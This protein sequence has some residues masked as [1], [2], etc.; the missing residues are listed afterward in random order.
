MLICINLIGILYEES[1]NQFKKIHS[2]LPTP[3]KISKET[4][5][6]QFIHVSALGIENA[7]DSAYAISKLEGEKGVRENFEN[8]VILKPS[9]VYSIDDNF[10]TNF[11]T[12]LS[13]FPL[14]PL[15]IM[16]KQSL[17]LYMFQI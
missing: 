11:M 7:K 13:R 3:I 14:M 15:F 1:K 9:I 8:A 5:I 17:Y 16:G 10:T 6:D 4:D 2:K 12:L